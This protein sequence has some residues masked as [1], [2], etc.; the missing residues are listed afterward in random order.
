M[1]SARLTIMSSFIAAP[2]ESSNLKNLNP[3]DPSLFSP[4]CYVNVYVRMWQFHGSSD[5]ANFYVTPATSAFYSSSSPF[6]IP[7]DFAISSLSSF[8]STWAWDSISFCSWASLISKRSSC[9]IASEA[10]NLTSASLTDC[11]HNSSAFSW[12]WMAS[13]KSLSELLWKV[14]SLSSSKI[15]NEKLVMKP[16]SLTKCVRSSSIFDVILRIDG[17]L[18][19]PKSS[20]HSLLRSYFVKGIQWL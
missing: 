15:M 9:K 19:D 14:D 20:S 13:K 3:T 18:S 12:S 2:A 17:F 5:R 8:S 6:S 1:L 4:F 10:S 11:L 7:S 16:V